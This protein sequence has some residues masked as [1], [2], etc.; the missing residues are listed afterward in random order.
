MKRISIK[1]IALLLLPALILL[2]ASFWW[3]KREK[4]DAVKERSGPFRLEAAK[5]EVMPTPAEVAEGYDTKFLVTF[6]FRG[7]GSSELYPIPSSANEHLSVLETS[8]IERNGKKWRAIPANVFPSVRTKGYE[9]YYIFRP[10]SA[11][12]SCRFSAALE[13]SQ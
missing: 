3:Q 5:V 8:V 6:A 4:R 7:K 1:E 12:A 9:G 11:N 13:T 2:G 10:I